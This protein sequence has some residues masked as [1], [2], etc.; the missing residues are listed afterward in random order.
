MIAI[1]LGAAVLSAGVP[2]EQP[3][4]VD[5]PVVKLVNVLED[6][7]ADRGLIPIGQLVARRVGIENIAG[8]GLKLR[9]VGTSC[10]CAIAKLGAEFLA[11]GDSTKLELATTAES[12]GSKQWYTADVEVTEQSAEQG[13][14]RRE[15]FRVS[16]GYLPDVQAVVFPHMVTMY[17]VS[18]R[19]EEF[20]L[21]VRRLDGRA[22]S[23]A[24]VNLPGEWLRVS[25]VQPSVEDARQQ[26]ITLAPATAVPG[27][28]R[29]IISVK[30]DGEEAAANRLDAS[31]RV[32]P[33]WVTLPAGIVWRETDR[34][35]PAEARVRI[36]SRKGT[37]RAAGPFSARITDPCPLLKSVSIE[38]DAAADAGYVLVARLSV[39][40]SQSITH[41][42]SM[43]DV[44]DSQGAVVLQVPIV[45]FGRGSFP[46]P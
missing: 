23:V 33:E 36:R 35:W 45:W 28:Y 26:I 2:Q 37:A 41:G 38:Q 22:V 40:E 12:V 4:T 34:G 44:V 25:R 19:K 1:M 3:P 9:V 11:P 30:V 43:I 27:I 6:E 15:R 16:I 18:G 24:D 14:P 31:L 39:I 46:K 42:S 13:I 21:V 17:S 8:V 5:A 10:P 29:G 32:E 20:E 7:P